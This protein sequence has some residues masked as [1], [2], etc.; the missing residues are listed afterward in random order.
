MLI[1]ATNQPKNESPQSLFALAA[2]FYA[3]GKFTSHLSLQWVPYPTQIVGKGNLSHGKLLTLT[4]FPRNTITIFVFSFPFLFI[5]PLIAT[6]FPRIRWSEASKPIPVMLLG[7]LIGRKKYTLR[8]VIFVLMIVFGVMLFIFKDKYEEKDGE[9]PLLGSSLIGVSLLFDGLCGATEDRL[10]SFAKPTALNFMHY[11]AL[12]S[13]GIQ[14]I[15]VVAFGEGPKFFDFIQ[16]HPDIIKYFAAILCV[17]AIGQIFISLMLSS[18]G[19]L[20]LSITT[21]TRK[22]FSVILSVIIFQNSLSLRQ[23]CA[24]GIIFGTLFLDGVLS[25]KM[26][27]PVTSEEDDKEQHQDKIDVAITQQKYNDNHA[28][29]I[30]IDETKNHHEDTKL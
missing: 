8:K 19:A 7:V 25:K 2:L 27:A 18:Y 5:A 22:F 9:D 6:L 23:W 12:W 11:L 4:N 30:G 15:G 1:L 20:P 24:A 26:V 13:I 21:T 17:G 29:D 14:I 10:R 16:R 3:L 28:M